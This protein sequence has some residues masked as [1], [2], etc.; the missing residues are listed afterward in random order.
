ML[1]LT[2][3]SGTLSVTNKF[4]SSTKNLIASEGSPT[5]SPTLLTANAFTEVFLSH[6]SAKFSSV[7]K[8]NV[9]AGYLVDCLTNDNDESDKLNVIVES[10]YRFKGGLITSFDYR[11]IQLNFINASQARLNAIFNLKTTE[12]DLI[13]LIG[14]LIR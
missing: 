1:N 7:Q 2:S 13:K 4:G 14:G 5:T 8:S 12:T 9:N 3:S 11:T 10:L 6:S